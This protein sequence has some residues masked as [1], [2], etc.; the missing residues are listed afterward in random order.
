MGF[1]RWFL[2]ISEASWD[3]G[4]G[5]TSGIWDSDVSAQALYDAVISQGYGK[6]DFRLYVATGT[7]DEAFGISTSQMISLLEYDDMFKPGDNTSCSM[8]IGGTHSIQAVYTYLY[9]ILPSLFAE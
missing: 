9:H 2:P 4:E 1:F 8:M 6:D 3:D 7:E 5:G